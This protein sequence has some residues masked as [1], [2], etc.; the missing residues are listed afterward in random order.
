MSCIG[1]A[2]ETIMRRRSMGVGRSVLKPLLA[3]WHMQMG[4]SV[5]AGLN[6][7]QQTLGEKKE[8]PPATEEKA[9]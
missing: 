2:P 8:K 6:Q 3:M 1:E 9:G 7:S 4:A 5:T